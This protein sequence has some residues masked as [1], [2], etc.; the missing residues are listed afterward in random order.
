MPMKGINDFGFDGFTLDVHIYKEH[1]DGHWAQDHYLVH[2][3]DD[4]VWT[5]SIDAVVNYLRAELERLEKE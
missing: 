1:G 2:G 5:D 3:I 4:V